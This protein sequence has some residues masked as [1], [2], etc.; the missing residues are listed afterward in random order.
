MDMPGW[1]QVL[2]LGCGRVVQFD[3]FKP[4]RTAPEHLDGRKEEVTHNPDGVIDPVFSFC[5]GFLNGR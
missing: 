3:N 2:L 5:S 1:P 4:P